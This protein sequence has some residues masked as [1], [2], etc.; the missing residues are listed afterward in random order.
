M[1]DTVTDTVTETLT[2]TVTDAV[3]E[4]RDD[5][6]DAVA[7]SRTGQWREAMPLDEPWEG[8]MEG[9]EVD[10]HKILLV[11]I[12]G[13]IRAY[14]NRCPH[15]AWELSDGDFDGENI[16]CCRHLWTFNA[17]SGQGVNPENCQLV[18]YPCSVVDGM[19]MV[20]VT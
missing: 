11:N 20:D 9:V 18:G 3:S 7:D 15:Q 14:R 4:T 2:D 8:E 12:D 5:T 19:I 13:E 17:E 16:T 10:G 1:T 6:A